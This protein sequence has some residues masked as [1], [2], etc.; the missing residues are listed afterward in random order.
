MANEIWV[1]G[2][3]ELL[4]DDLLKHETLKPFFTT[5]IVNA[6]YVRLQNN[7]WISRY[8]KELNA[9]VGFT[10]EGA[11]FYLLGLKLTNQLPEVNIDFIQSILKNGSK[12]QKAAIESFLCEQAL[13]GNL[14]L[15]ANLIDA[16]NDAIDLSITPLLFYLK[17]VGVNATIEKVLENPTEND[18]IALKK[19]DGQLEELQLHI[20]R[21]DFLTALMPQNEFQT[22]EAVILC[23][24]AA[25]I[26]DKEVAIFSLK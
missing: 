18:W 7:G 5:D 3:N 1:K 9:H 4:L 22:K 19:L 14:D 25:A 11:L 24:K 16:G 23:L 15:V 20:L 2:E 13:N 17:N 21:K 6:P 26:L 10:V 8:V 12:L